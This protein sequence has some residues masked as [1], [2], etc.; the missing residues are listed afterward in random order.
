MVASDLVL[1]KVSR[2]DA[3]MKRFVALFLPWSFLKAGTLTSEPELHN[4]LLIVIAGPLAAHLDDPL[5]V[6]TLG[7][8]EPP[9][10]LEILVIVDLNVKSAGVLN[11]IIICR[12][13]GLLLRGHPRCIVL[14]LRLR[15]LGV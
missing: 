8:N 10:N 12:Q 13:V 7:S 2:T 3:Q 15:Q 5:H 11:I 14:Q 1:V 6:A 9:C 4:F